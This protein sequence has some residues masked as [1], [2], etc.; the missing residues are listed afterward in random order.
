MNIAALLLAAGNS[1]RMGSPKQLLEYQGQPLVRRAA[2]TAIAAHL[3]PVIVI[4]G[5]SS[6]EIRPTLADLPVDILENSEWPRGMG[7]TL[8]TGIQ[9]LM[10]S[11]T[12][13]PDAVLLL[14]CDQ[15][16]ITPGHLIA[17]LTEH[18]RTQ[19]PLIAA[20]YNGTHGVPALIS[21]KYFAELQSL[22]D[23]G[24]AKSLFSRHPDDLATIPL[25][26]A[27]LDIDDPAAYAYLI[28]H[29]P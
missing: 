16:L 29:T 13:P 12:P 4:L 7:T 23:A 20:A 9:H 14:L 6:H 26:E 18:E 28:R 1:S 25:P 21:K 8:R 19:K 2:E 11:P 17:L 24:G 27:A 22:P 10:N 5:A 15:P 3:S